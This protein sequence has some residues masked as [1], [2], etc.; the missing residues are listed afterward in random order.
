MFCPNCGTEN[1]NDNKHCKECGSPLMNISIP[2]PPTYRSAPNAFGIGFGAI[3]LATMYLLPIIPLSSLG[4]VTLSDY[5]S[6]CSSGKLSTMLYGCSNTNVQWIF[7][8]GW[9]AA[10]FFLVSGLFHKEEA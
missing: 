6:K 3:I 7:Y 10:I 8:I 2:P 1:P 9:I 4:L 5:A